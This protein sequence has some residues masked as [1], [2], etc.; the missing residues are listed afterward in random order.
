EAYEWVVE[1]VDNANT[2]DTVDA[3]IGDTV[4]EGFSGLPTEGVTYT[5]SNEDVFTVVDGEAI[6]NRP[7]KKA[8]TVTLTVRVVSDEIA[9]DGYNYANV[10]VTRT[11]TFTVPAKGN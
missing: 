4:T 8:A 11:F 9:G 10:D 1:A 5:S 2:F 3:L 6:V 7:N